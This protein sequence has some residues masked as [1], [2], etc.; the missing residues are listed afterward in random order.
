MP[1]KIKLTYFLHRGRAEASRFI[2]A[3]AGVDY[4]D[5]RIGRDQWPSIKPSKSFITS[6]VC[7]PFHE[8]QLVHTYIYTCEIRKTLI[9]ILSFP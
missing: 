8:L 9:L 3:Q 1:A 2:L 7:F 6:G 5:H 4:E